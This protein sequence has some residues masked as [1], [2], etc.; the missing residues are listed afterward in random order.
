MIANASFEDGDPI[1][2]VTYYGLDESLRFPITPEGW[3]HWSPWPIDQ[4]PTWPEPCDYAPVLERRSVEEHLGLVSQ[5]IT[6]FPADFYDEEILGPEHWRLLFYNHAYSLDALAHS[7]FHV[8]NA[9]RAVC[10]APDFEAPPACFLGTKRPVAE[11]IAET[12][13]ILAYPPEGPARAAWVMLSTAQHLHLTKAEVLHCPWWQPDYVVNAGIFYK[14]P[15]KAVEKVQHRP[16][17]HGNSGEYI[18]ELF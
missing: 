1:N 15:E 13:D 6:R 10:D 17:G 14:S 3:A 8:V 9:L 4:E 2:E 11:I 5:L 16:A 12:R 7:R 18:D